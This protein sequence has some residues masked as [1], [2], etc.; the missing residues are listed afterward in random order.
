MKIINILFIIFMTQLHALTQQNFEYDRF[1]EISILLAV[2]LVVVSSF[3]IYRHYELKKLNDKLQK[4]YEEEVKNSRDKDEIIFN[5]KKLAAMD[6]VLENIAHQ[7]RQPLSQVNSAVLVIDDRMYEKNFKDDVIEE[8]LLEIESLTKYMSKTIDDF[9]NFFHEQNKKEKFSIKDLLEKSIYII[10]GTLL[11][12]NIK[13]ENRVDR[14]IFYNGYPSELEQVILVL[15]NNAKDVLISRKIQYPKITL[16]GFKKGDY[17]YI[18]I[19]D[20]GG[21][22][23]ESI[24]DKIFDPYFTTKHKSQGTGLGLY[25]SQMMIKE[26]MNA[27]LSV[28]NS[29]IGAVFTIKLKVDNAE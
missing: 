8:K 6:E 10:K 7:W 21:G 17:C 18:I 29:K 24:I 12:L 11:A 22:I 16:D 2:L 28:K 25:I 23:D 9:K 15:L 20:N 3:L 14:K 4:Y 13:V 5:Q 26:K 19:E 27:E 1:F